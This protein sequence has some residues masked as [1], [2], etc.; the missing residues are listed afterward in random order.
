MRID[1]FLSQLNFCSRNDVKNFLKTYEV[2]IDDQRILDRSYEFNPELQKLQIDG[3]ITF[4]ENPI[5]LMIF[6]PIGF[7]SANKDKLH[8]CVVEL[9]KAPYHRFEYAI[10]GRLDIDAEGLVILT[11]D[12]T[13]AHQITHPKSHLP[14]TYQVT[15]DME[16]KHEKELI[17]G[18]MIKDGKNELYLAKAL[19][20]KTS[21]NDVI[22][23]IDEGKF[24]QVKRMFQAVGYEVIHLKRTHIGHLSLG[25]LKPGEYRQ[26]RKESLYD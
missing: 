11:T 19:E 22:L 20:I 3:E 15:L 12:G 13:L 8:P 5:H 6:K 25:N 14:K 24:H 26:F 23:K 4:Y 9:I 17:K 10:A 1:K 16:F 2:I 18:V 21:Q 7:L